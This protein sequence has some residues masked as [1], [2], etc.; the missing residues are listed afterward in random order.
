M[1]GVEWTYRH[2]EAMVQKA[3]DRKGFS[4]LIFFVAHGK[5]IATMNFIE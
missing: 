4:G 2:L 3:I 1:E 5:E